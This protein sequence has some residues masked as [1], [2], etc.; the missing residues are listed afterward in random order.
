MAAIRFLTF[1]PDGVHY[2]ANFAMYINE[3][4]HEFDDISF[5]EEV[6]ACSEDQ[7]NNPRGRVH[8]HDMVNHV[9]HVHDNAATWGHF[10]ENLG[11][12]LGDNYLKTD[13]GVLVGG[14]DKILSFILNGEEV[15]SVSN[16]VIENHDILLISYGAT[17]EA[18]LMEQYNQIPTD[19]QKHNA[20]HDP[21]ACAGAYEINFSDKLLYSFGLKQL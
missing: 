8:M 13:E 4:K 2:H 18:E 15:S 21:S 10:F 1:V 14:D 19:A 7:L 12:G 5:Y 20:I 3:Q 6:Q 16:K 17:D 9:V 11:Y